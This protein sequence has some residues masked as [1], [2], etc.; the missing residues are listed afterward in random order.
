M[1]KLFVSVT[2]LAFLI[3]AGCGK[4]KSEIEAEAQR[5]DKARLAVQKKLADEEKQFEEK[6]KGLAKTAEDTALQRSNTARLLTEAEQRSG[7]ALIIK[8]FQEKLL[9][10]LKDP[11]SAQFRDVKL[12]NRRDALCGMV[13]SKNSYGGYNGF[14]GFVV[15]EENA[16]MQTEKNDLEN[17]LYSGTAKQQGC[18]QER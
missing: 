16:F 13:N 5:A 3:A 7:D 17:L 15:T 9:T 1:K 12:N 2:A 8:K 6:L 11:S 4:S 10:R 18:I 14:S